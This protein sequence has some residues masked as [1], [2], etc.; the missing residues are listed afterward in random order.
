[1]E[2]QLRKVNKVKRLNASQKD[3]ASG[4]ASIIMHNEAPKNWNKSV[5]SYC[6]APVDTNQ[7]MVDAISNIC[8]EH[9]VSSFMG[10]VLY[11]SKQEQ[12]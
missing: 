9:Q 1:M 6:K 4:I 2:A 5:A 3:V 12:E 10:S 11:H 8:L 7:E